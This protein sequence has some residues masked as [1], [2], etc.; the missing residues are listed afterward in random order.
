MT[1]QVEYRS[2]HHPACL[3]PLVPDARAGDGTLATLGPRVPEA[4]LHAEPPRLFPEA[5]HAIWGYESFR[6]GQ[7]NIVRAS[8]QTARLLREPL[9]VA[10]RSATNARS[11]RPAAHRGSFFLPLIALMQDQVRN[12]NKWASPP[13]FRQ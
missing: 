4:E 1:K 8:L 10:S 7:D 3:L 5:L 11:P 12:S 9:V 6:P 13:L 2:P